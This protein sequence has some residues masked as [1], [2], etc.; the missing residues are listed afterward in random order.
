MNNFHKIEKK[1]GWYE[2]KSYLHLD[3]PLSFTKASEKVKNSKYI[4]K[5]PFLP[6]LRFVKQERKFNPK[7]Y[8]KDIRY[9]SK[10]R[11]I[12]Y[13]SHKDG[14]IYSYYAKIL[15]DAYENLLKKYQLDTNILAFRK[16][17]KKNSESGKS[18]IE[19]ANDVFNQIKDF[20]E[21]SV[22]AMDFSKFFNTLNHQLLKEQ[23]S[24]VLGVDKLPE[25]HFKV[26]KSLTNFSFIDR[27]KIY[28]K[29]GIS[30]NNPRPKDK[31]R[32]SICKVEKLRELIKEDKSISDKSKRL[33]QTNKESKG[34][35]Q[36]S[37]LS[38]L[39]SNIYM[40]NFD[41][42]VKEYIENMQG[43]YYR[44]CDDIIIIT[45]LGDVDKVDNFITNNFVKDLETVE[46]NKDKTEKFHFYNGKILGNKFLQYLGFIFDGQNI[47]LRSSSI[48]RY[49]RKM[50]RGIKLA[51]RTQIARNRIRTKKNLQNR[52]LYKNRIYER[53]SSLGN[54]NFI[55][56]VKRAI[57]IMDNSQTLKKQM[58]KFQKAFDTKMSLQV[59]SP[60]KGGKP[61]QN[62][63]CKKILKNR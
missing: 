13:A 37:A 23:W 40:I 33:L 57:K 17:K 47:Y 26:F 24:K 21:C 44:Y 9:K 56:Y 42:Q 29:L 6:F 43:K 31:N 16:I 39:L 5:Y 36:G 28:C 51:K 18:S 30:R 8:G 38:G 59:K 50:N 60:I 61:T 15:N 19:F 58:Q 46:I 20:G 63:F 22:L 55:S 4:E 54:R 2:S 25:D 7:K 52:E 48:S 11:E 53:Y 41:K 35:P 32:K 12:S 45:K 49:Y 3:T 34:I 27:D 14:Y 1:D 62:I 10:D